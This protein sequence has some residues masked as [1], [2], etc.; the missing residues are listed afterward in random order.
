MTQNKEDYIKISSER[1]DIPIFFK[2]WWLD[3]LCGLNN[4]TAIVIRGHN[5]RVDAIWPIPLT[6]KFGIKITRQPPL[7]PYLGFKIFMPSDISKINS[8]QKFRQKV[9]KQLI[10]AFQDI[11]LGY[12]NQRF[13]EENNDL[14]NF[15][16]NNLK[17]QIFNRYII[18]PINIENLISDF[19]GDIRT[20]IKKASGIV[21][22]KETS[23]C[24]NFYDLIN[25]S[26]SAS[27][28]TIP[29]SKDTF[30]KLLQSIFEKTT[31][32][33]IV[34]EKE[35]SIVGACLILIDNN[36][37]YLNCL[38]ISKAH[39]NSG[40]SSLL[41]YE[42]IKFAS[43][44]TSRFDFSGSMV[45][46]ISNFFRGFGGKKQNYTNVKFY[47]NKLFEFAHSILN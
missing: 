32:K 42:G 15:Y 17:Q 1:K 33:I 6:K 2:P 18:D 4:W 45:P 37:A 11:G 12:F 27:N 21:T 29:Y 19:D 30:E 43:T 20:N 25:Q 46:N 13:H 24:P 26:F 31:S 5:D 10:K 38:G 16:W 39:R 47:R 23:L 22:C 41:I 7:T 28:K 44:Q 3:I 8:Q 36:V 40:I 14:Q 9:A 34:A 35:D